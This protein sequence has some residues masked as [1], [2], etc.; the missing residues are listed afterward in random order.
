MY[1]DAGGWMRMR[2]SWP[3]PTVPLVV[4]GPE[5]RR[6]ILRLELSELDRAVGSEAS[7]AIMMPDGAARLGTASPF[8]CNRTTEVIRKT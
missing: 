1:D 4:S 5:E 8:G 3:E 2:V 6:L 7:H